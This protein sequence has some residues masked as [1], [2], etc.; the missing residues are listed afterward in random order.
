MFGFQ[1]LT[2]L[3]FKNSSI[4]PNL[5]KRRSGNAGLDTTDFSEKKF[6]IPNIELSEEEHDQRVNPTG[7]SDD[8]IS[9]GSEDLCSPGEGIQALD[10]AGSD[11]DGDQN[12]R[13]YQKY[14]DES[15]TEEIEKFEKILRQEKAFTSK[16]S[17]KNKLHIR[18]ME[19][20][21]SFEHGRKYKY[22]S[23]YYSNKHVRHSRSRGRERSRQR[24]WDDYELYQKTNKHQAK[25]SKVDE[26][27]SRK[28]KYKTEIRKSSVSDA[29]E[30][31]SLVSESGKKYK[32]GQSG[33]SIN[34]LVPQKNKE[35]IFEPINLTDSESDYDE[36][37][38]LMQSVG[39]QVRADSRKSK[40]S[41]TADVGTQISTQEMATQTDPHDY[42]N[43]SQMQATST[44]GTQM[45]PPLHIRLIKGH[46][47]GELS[48]IDKHSSY[49]SLIDQN[50]EVS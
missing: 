25:V 12:L 36:K 35:N 42:H 28:N 23:D 50:L 45:T 32:N 2:A 16:E 44:Q 10:R 15:E 48:L 40:G 34:V 19:Y 43:K 14:S 31:L 18:D 49:S 24:G 21:K 9:N 3:A 8:D 6:Q 13:V 29:E 37:S 7:F 46:R 1:I 33:R 17:Y 5:L 41:V 27:L 30:L 26:R 11:S 4:L 22:R 38:Q 47:N 39:L 20:E